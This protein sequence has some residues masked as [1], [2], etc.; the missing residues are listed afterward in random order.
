VTGVLVGDALHLDEFRESA[1]PGIV[2]NA[3][4]PIGP[5]A[6]TTSISGDRISIK[7]PPEPITGPFVVVNHRA[8]ALEV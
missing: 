2:L 4:T 1:I 8:L 7:L 3:V 5:D 6:V